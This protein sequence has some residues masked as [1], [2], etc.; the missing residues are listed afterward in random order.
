ML[1]VTDSGGGGTFTVTVP[2]LSG[3]NLVG[4]AC[5]Q[6]SP[7]AIAD[8]LDSIDGEYSIVYGNENGSWK[9]Y[10]PAQPFG[11]SLTEMKTGYGYWIKATQ[12]TTWTMTCHLAQ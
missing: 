7:E 12:A 11:H 9:T 5:P 10:D 4:Y 2:L 3:W 1:T 6:P 8:A